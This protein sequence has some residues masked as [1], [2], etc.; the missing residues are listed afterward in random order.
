M[1]KFAKMGETGE[2]MGV[3]NICLKY[4]PRNVKYDDRVQ[5]SNPSH[6]SCIDQFVR[7]R[8]G[9]PQL[10]LA[11]Y[12]FSISI[13]EHVPLKLLITKNVYQ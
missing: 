5:R 10:S 11:V 2:P 3:P 12:P 6:T 1:T 7:S 9:I 8:T 13:D 4:F